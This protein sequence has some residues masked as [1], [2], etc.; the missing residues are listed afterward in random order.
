VKPRF[1][2][3][4]AFTCGL[5]VMALE[6]SASR[7][8]APYFGTSLFVWTNVIGVVLAVLSLG[9]Y[10]GGRLAERRPDPLLL[11]R[12]IL[13]TGLL[14]LAIPWAARPLALGLL[15]AG[16][17]IRSGAL[18]ILVASFLTTLL[19]FGA[20]LVLLGMVSPFII[21]LYSLEEQRI[22]D[23]TGS[24]FAVSTV[25]SLL[26]T[27]LPALCLI[28]L[29]GTRRTVLL[30]ACV[31]ILLGGLP[32]ATWAGRLAVLA[33]VL[34]ALLLPAR[35]PLR[36]DSRL[37]TEQ[38]SVHHYI[39]VLRDEDGTLSMAYNEGEAF[40]SIY[41]PQHILTGYYYD[42]FSTL[43]DLVEGAPPVRV[44]IIG[45]AGG[46]LARQLHHYYGGRVSL[47]AVELDEAV[48]GL[49]RR[50]FGLEA[51]PVS[52]HHQDGRVFL[53]RSEA[54]YDLIVVDAYQNERYIPWTMTT[55][56][57][58]QQVRER[59]TERG[60]VAINIF[61]G[62]PGSPLTAAITNT[63]A[64]VFPYVYEAQVDTSNS[65]VTAAPHP[66]S[67]AE[68]PDRTQDDELVPLA[69]ELSEG[70]ARV[71]HDPSGP[72][73]TDDRAPVEWLSHRVSF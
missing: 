51:V 52:V 14:C 35:G 61:S 23:L 60:L 21:K 67:F 6:I 72:L 70:A 13:V 68:L 15:A 58:W 20:P 59:L 30:L 45:L 1:L 27:F 47:E 34:A 40:Q 28:P 25:G 3:I 39:R 4:V 66:L 8:L 57:F 32:R 48:D 33:L 16:A 62:G 43:P 41:H 73:L 5:V 22:G 46:T 7:L 26:G 17:H 38:E 9:Y 53:A 24:V 37:V 2:L 63:M 11:L 65:L 64:G 54:Q 42:T 55:R 10:S 56:E 29:L 19:L 71:T 36:P 69:E 12:L 44:L 18:H 49:A 31:L 50:Y